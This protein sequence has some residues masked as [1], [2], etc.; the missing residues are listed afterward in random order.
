MF[1]HTR[2]P[3][4]LCIGLGNLAAS[5]VKNRKA[6]ALP[7]YPRALDFL[8]ER[9]PAIAPKDMGGAAMAE[10]AERNSPP[11]PWRRRRCGTPP[12]DWAAKR[13]GWAGVGAGGAERAE[14]GR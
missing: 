10:A 14:L 12:W 1:Q 3:P 13:A 2:H 7:S 6:S 11:R 9:T 4:P 8:W 5:L